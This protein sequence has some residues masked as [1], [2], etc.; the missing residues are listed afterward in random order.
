MGYKPTAKPKDY[1][2]QHPELMRVVRYQTKDVQTK[3]SFINNS[4]A[5]ELDLFS[6]NNGRIFIKLKGGKTFSST[7]QN[8]TA[9]FSS[10]KYG[11]FQCSLQCGDQKILINKNTALLS[12]PEFLDIFT[13]LSSCGYVGG[14]SE[15]NA[16]K[17]KYELTSKAKEKVKEFA[18]PIIPSTSVSKIQKP[19]Q[20]LLNETYSVF[21]P[22]CGKE[23]KPGSKFCQH[24][25][26]Q[27]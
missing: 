19:S 4:F 7:I 26:H 17:A 27:L 9:T 15:F 22:S 5:S 25:G 3:Y 14:M 20:Q 16:Y 1:Y 21:C 8:T 10:G 11:L 24:C 23:N 2:S 12:A 6:Y 18:S 13:I